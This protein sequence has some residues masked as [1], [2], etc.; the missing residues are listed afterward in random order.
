MRSLIPLAIALFAAPAALADTALLIANTRYDD[1]QNLRQ[2]GDIADLQRPLDDAGFDVITVENG[3]TAQLRAALSMLLAA[4]EEDR[5]LIAVAGHMAHARSGS[6]LLGSDADAPDLG[7]VGGQGVSLDVLMELAGRAPG[8]AMVLI[9][10]EQRNIDLGAGLAAGLGPVDAPQGVTVISGAPGEVVTFARRVALRPG[11]DLAGGVAASRNL[12]SHGFLSPAVP[13]LEMDR[14]TGADPEETMAPEAPTAQ[15]TALW[16]AVRELNTQGSFRAYLEQFPDGAYAAEARSEID[17]LTAQP[18][19]PADPQAEAEAA[20]AA[21]QLSRAARQQ[22]QRDLTLLDHDTRGIDGIF[23]PGTR[24][25][26]R[27]WQRAAGFADTGFLTSAQISLLRDRATV[28]AAELEEEARIE[29][30]AREQEDRA[31]WQAIGQGQ[32]EAGLRS[33]LERFPNGLYAEVAQSRLD[34]IEAARRIEAEADER[35]DWDSVREADTPGAYRG[36][37]EAYPEGLF[38]DAARARIAELDSGM[39]PDA[40]AQAEARE[41][42]LNL[43]PPMRRLVEERLASMGLNSGPQDGTF[44][45][46]TRTAIR[47]Y[48]DG[49]GLPATGYLDQLTMVRLLA[50]AIGGRLFD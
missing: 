50:E 22:I 26:I 9:G 35:A 30:A 40:Q 15:E 20:E 37:L 2:A 11:A 23:G 12:S 7:T 34:D 5:V 32:D 17:R 39:S 49:R 44:D 31:Y 10:T 33:Y 6:W 8:R 27:G 13:F 3:T 29:R 46:Q 24:S 38:V 16:R 14:D 43:A 48:Q 36:Y 47:T 41:A 28:R 4:E 18:A 45:G 1:A 19:Q 21:L 25:A 42:A